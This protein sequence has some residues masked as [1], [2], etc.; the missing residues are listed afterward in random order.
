MAES[1]CRFRREYP[2]A[3]APFLRERT[4]CS[5]TLQQC[6]QQP[7]KYDKRCRAF[8][9]P[10]TAVCNLRGKNTAGESLC[11]T[12]SDKAARPPRESPGTDTDKHRPQE[13]SRIKFSRNCCR[14]GKQRHGCS[15][16][17]VE[18]T[19]SK[20]FTGHFERP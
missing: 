4:S 9:N 8:R 3:T 20:A 13:K 10:S 17:S 5:R 7:H 15:N 19:A 1:Y 2:P 16:S 14:S 11:C 18:N 12:N 6:Y